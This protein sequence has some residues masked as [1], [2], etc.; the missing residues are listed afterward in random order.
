MRR[1]DD[2]SFVVDYGRLQ[3]MV[4]DT[5]WAK[6][7]R[8]LPHRGPDGEIDGVRLTGMTRASVGAALGLRNGDVVHTVNGLAVASPENGVAL[9]AMV[10][11]GQRVEA[12]VTRRGEPITLVWEPGPVPADE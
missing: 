6:G 3:A 12:S 10:S 7:G 11:A 2:A 4:A 9:Y 1:I 5:D 8:A